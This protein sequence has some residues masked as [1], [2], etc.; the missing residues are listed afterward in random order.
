MSRFLFTTLFSNDLGLPNRTV[1]IA[2]ELVK[3]GHEVAFCNPEVAPTK[4]ITEAGLHNLEFRS[5]ALP[6]VIPPFTQRIRNMDHFYAA[7]GYQDEDFLR[8]D[9][10][11]MMTVAADYAPDV[12]IDSWNLSSCIAARTLRKPLVSIIQ[13]DMHPSNQG[14]IWWEELAEDVPTP[15]PVLNRVLADYDIQPVSKTEELHV[16]DLTLVAGTP[17]T[18]PLP[19]GADSVYVGPILWQKMGAKLPDYIDALDPKRLVIWVYTGNPHYFE[20]FVTW[21]DS[22]VVLRACIAAL[23]EEDMQVVVTTGYHDLPVESASLPANFHYE[24]Y[25]PGIAMAERSDLMIHHGGHGA[26]LTGPYTGTPAIIIP[27][28]SERESNARRIAGLGAADFIVP[29][30]DETAEKHVSVEEVRAKVKHV[31]SNSSYADSARH[32]SRKMRSYGG[33]SEAARLITDFAARV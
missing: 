5:R 30:E 10:E 15:V 21:G 22:I 17:D 25:V 23:A 28:F 3:R 16:G 11:G 4:L 2:F 33:A 31:L 6:T 18:D 14:F 26:S 12:I 29:V 20:P 32:L 24:S 19:E 27:T 9:C 8:V 13:G 1:P 7:Y